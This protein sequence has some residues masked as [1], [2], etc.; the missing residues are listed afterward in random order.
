[1]TNGPASSAVRL[2]L[3]AGGAIAIVALIFG[4]TRTLIEEAERR[5][6]LAM[7][8]AVLPPGPFDNEVE[9]DWIEVPPNALLGENRS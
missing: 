1:M 3:I 5:A 2:G 8:L 9:T 4:A 7:V 6:E